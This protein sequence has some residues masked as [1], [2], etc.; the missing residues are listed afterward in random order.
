MCM[1]IVI[2]AREWTHRN[3]DVAAVRVYHIQ[4]VPHAQGME[5]PAGQL[6]VTFWHACE[7]A[8]LIR[9]GIQGLVKGVQTPRLV[10]GLL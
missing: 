8:R 4:R 3:E 10:M 5:Q 2:L 9:A 1:V 7:A 6:E